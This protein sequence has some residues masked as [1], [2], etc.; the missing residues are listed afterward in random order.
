M[1]QALTPPATT[2]YDLDF[3]AWTEA[4]VGHLRSGNFDQLDL[5]NL[6]E[7]IEALGK[8][9]KQELR[10]RLNTLLEHLLKR[11]YVALPDE[12]HGWECTIREQRKQ[13]A[14]LL[15]DSPSLKSIWEKTFE[16]A[17]RSALKDLRQEYRSYQF[18]DTWQYSPAIDDLLNVNFWE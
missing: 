2:L 10:S 17:W 6:I 18:P 5:E 13:L 12:Y 15:E 3:L 4:T 16:S 11:I 8:S 7:E 9:E 1:T 14:W